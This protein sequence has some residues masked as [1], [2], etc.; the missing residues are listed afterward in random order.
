[1]RGFDPDSENSQDAP[2]KHCHDSQLALQRCIKPP[3][4]G[5]RQY[6]DREIGDDA[7]GAICHKDIFLGGDAVTTDVRVP[8][9]ADWRTSENFDEKGRYV[10]EDHEDGQQPR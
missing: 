1:M 4:E 2:G 9:F 3:H 7:D 8:N 6:K 5:H 10:V